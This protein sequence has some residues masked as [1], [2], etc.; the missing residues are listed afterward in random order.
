[1]RIVIVD[2]YYQAFLDRHYAATPGLARRSFDEQLTSLME[3]YFGTS[4]AYSRHLGELGHQAIDLVA[5]CFPLQDRWAKDHGR[6]GALRRAAARL[7]RLPERTA[8]LPFLHEVAIAQVEAADAEVV[9]MQD[10]SFFPRSILD[11]FR[12]Q[13][14][15]VVGQIASGLPDEERLRGFDLILTSFPHY[16]ERLRGIG[17]ASEYLP[18]AFYGRVLDR[19]RGE[20]VDPVAEGK[21]QHDLAFAGGL[22][23]SVH[24]ERVELLERVARE[25]PLEVWGYGAQ[26]LP[27]DSAI[28]RAHRGEAWGIEMYRVLAESRLVLNSHIGYAEGFANNMRLFEATGVGALL[29]TESAPNL[30]NFFELD[31]EV[32]S[33]DGPANLVEKLRYYIEHDDERRAIAAAGQARTLRD[34]TYAKLMVRLAD[35]LEARLS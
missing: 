35:I 15:L 1:M 16:P 4:D 31:R 23:P 5:N 33:Y 19:L 12:S 32:V 27:P 28:R 17:V 8:R 9:Y 26:L 6:P 7:Q 20:G 29:V 21:R 22:D 30:A 2:T 13:G 3:R 25:L 14:R 24:G 11:R 10:L 18:I 34:H